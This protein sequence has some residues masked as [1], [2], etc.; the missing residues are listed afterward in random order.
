MVLSFKFSIFVTDGYCQGITSKIIRI[1]D[2][3]I[4]GILPWREG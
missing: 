3:K 4:S 1:L 2:A